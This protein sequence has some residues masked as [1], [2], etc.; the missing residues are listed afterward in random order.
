MRSD[1]DGHGRHRAA[2]RVAQPGVAQA[3]V[4]QSGVAQAGVAWRW[5]LRLMWRTWVG[6]VSLMMVPDE[7][8]YWCHEGDD[9][10]CP[11]TRRLRTYISAPDGFDIGTCGNCQT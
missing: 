1:D 6:V 10:R 4:A 3:G 2:R 7:G 5:A 11:P 8:D 9:A